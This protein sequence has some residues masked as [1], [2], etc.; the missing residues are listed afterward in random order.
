[1]IYTLNLHDVGV[2]T[3]KRGVST[4]F[5]QIKTGSYENARKSAIEFTVED[6]NCSAVIVNTSTGNRLYFQNGKEV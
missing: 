5:E 6:H 4:P 1:M 2:D 3:V